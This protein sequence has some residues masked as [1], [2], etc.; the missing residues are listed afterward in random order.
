[1]VGRNVLVGGDK[2]IEVALDPAKTRAVVDTRPLRFRN[3]TYI[4][5]LEL[6]L[7]LDR[8]VLVKEGLA[9]A[10]LL[11]YRPDRRSTE[12]FDHLVDRHAARLPG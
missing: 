1:M 6:V 2:Q 11:L 8:K 4:V 9:S 3:R 12:L 10:S 7:E 5:C